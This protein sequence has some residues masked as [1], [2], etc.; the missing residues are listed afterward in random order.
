M[1][2][3]KRK[4]VLVSI[5]A[6][7]GRSHLQPLADSGFEL[8]ERYDLAKGADERALVEGLAGA[9]ATVAGVER[10]NRFV[11]ENSSTLKAIARC[12]VGSDSVDV[13]AATEQSVAVL[14]TPGTNVDSVA[15][16][17]LTLMLA[18]LRRVLLID[19][20]VRS[21][22][23]RPEGLGRDLA[24]SSVGIVGLGRIGQAV[25][26]RLAGFGC[27]ILAV[28]PYPNKEFC[29]TMGIELVSLD[30]LLPQVDV[31]TVHAPLI[32]E[33]RR[34]ISSA[35]L[36]L[37]QPHAVLVNTSRGDVVDEAAL[38]E[39]LETGRLAAAGLDVFES[40]PLPAGSPLTHLQNV[41]LGGHI[42]TYTTQTVQKIMEA[43]VSNLLEFDAGGAP[44]GWVN[45]SPTVKA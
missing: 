5:L 29:D 3:P 30:E 33:T 44:E 9:W 10:Y 13:D 32:P 22:S 45:P 15:D 2:A 6:Q 24:G 1:S 12:G 21:G 41:V 25:A 28:E 35:Q 7:L 19:E 43:I 31:L 18:C 36:A 4:I 17:A 20:A 39:A 34:M 11:L 27:R 42:A 38:V 23:W 26:Q 14:T 8:V 40:E 16:H 37:L